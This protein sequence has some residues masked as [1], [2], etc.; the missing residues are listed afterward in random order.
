V[1][2]ARRG[3]LLALRH[4]LGYRRCLGGTRDLEVVA[5]T[6][7]IDDPRVVRVLQDSH[8]HALVETF[9]IVAEQ[10]PRAATHLAGARRL[11]A[12]GKLTDRASNK[13]ERFGASEP[14]TDCANGGPGGDARWEGEGEGEGEGGERSSPEEMW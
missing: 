1:R 2:D 11:V 14:L 12:G 8:E 7:E 3:R 4:L 9:R 5:A 10:L 13:V 6:A